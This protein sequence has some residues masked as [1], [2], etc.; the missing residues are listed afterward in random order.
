MLSLENSRRLLILARIGFFL[1]LAAI[2]V[3]T[4]GPFQGDE[5]YVL[6]SDKGAHGLAFY[7]L[8]VAAIFAFPRVPRWSI[9]LVCSFSGGLVEILQGMTGRDAELLDWIAD[10]IG[11]VMAVAPIFFVQVYHRRLQ[12]R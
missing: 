12:R 5:K 7:G 11:A 2:F 8:A 10:S 9:I 6:L 4:L 3:V 1:L